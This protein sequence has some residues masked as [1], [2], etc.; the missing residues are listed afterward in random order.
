MKWTPDFFR[1]IR[2]PLVTGDPTTVLA[3][4]DSIVLSQSLARKFF[5]SANPVGRTLAVNKTSC[6]G[7]TVSCANEVVILR[8]TGIMADLPHNTHMRAEA[9]MP[10]TSPA[11]N[12]TQESKKEWF[13]VNGYGY[14]RLA[15][16]SDPR[17]VE[18]KIPRLLDQHVDVLQD[19]GMPLRAS[20]TIQISLVPLGRRASG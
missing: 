4:P 13:N 10:H 14:V 15:P 9:L 19:L 8:V 20:K 3:R 1:V 17:A 12:I 7:E 16:G 2:F 11:D 5:G 6:T 18:A